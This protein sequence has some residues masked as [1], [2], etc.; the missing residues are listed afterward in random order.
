MD[1]LED[2]LHS[3]PM[4]NRRPQRLQQYHACQLNQTIY[5]RHQLRCDRNDLI[6]T[7]ARAVA[8]SNC[9]SQPFKLSSTRF[10]F[11]DVCFISQNSTAL[12]EQEVTRVTTFHRDTVTKTTEFANFFTRLLPFIHPHLLEVLTS[13]GPKIHEC[14]NDRQ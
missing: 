2:A 4:S 7:S 9:S 8:A 1:P 10:E 6:Q 12:W 14:V 3:Y 5:L 11:S 13:A